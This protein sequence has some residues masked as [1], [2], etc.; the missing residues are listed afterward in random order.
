MTFCDGRGKNL[1]FE[2][3]NMWKLYDGLRLYGKQT[4]FIMERYEITN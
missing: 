1:S 4:H 2:R 3:Q